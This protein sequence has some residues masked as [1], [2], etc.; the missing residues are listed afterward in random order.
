[1]NILIS[2]AEQKGKASTLKKISLGAG[3]GPIAKRYITNA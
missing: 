2:F 3:T 1:M